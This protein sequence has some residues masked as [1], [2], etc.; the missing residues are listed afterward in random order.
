MR[1]R[2]DGLDQISIFRSL[3]A[4]QR[5]DVQARCVW[6]SFAEQQTIVQHEDNSTDVY[7][8]LS[9]RARVL[10]YSAAG[11]AVDFRDFKAGQF[12]GEYSAIDGRKRSA[13]VVALERCSVASMPGATFRAVLER[14]P[15]VMLTLLEAAV[16]QI[17]TLTERVVEFST[18]PVKVRIHAEVLR[19]A[20]AGTISG[21]EARVTSPPTHHEIA[22][23]ISTNREAVTRE[24]NHM[25]A[26]GVI[27]RNGTHELV[28][29]LAELRRLLDGERGD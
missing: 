4:E 22:N 16:A 23:R 27:Q 12:F 26:I 7:F 11:R 5:A 14:Y 8:L 6:K 1:S 9:G 21:N 29:Y 10:I 28:C 24:L 13:N 19:L 2:H 15:T 17:R 25:E 3:T 20:M 18:L